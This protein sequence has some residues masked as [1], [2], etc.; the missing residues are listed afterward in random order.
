[1]SSADL[2]AEPAHTR[3]GGAPRPRYRGAF[4]RLFR[5]EIRLIL[6]RRRNI[7]LLVVLAMVPMFIGIAVDISKPRHGD[8][9]QFLGQITG[10]G[11]FLVFT[12]LT[13]SLPFFF[14]LVVG[15]ISGDCIAGEANIGTLRYLLTVPVTRGRLL[16]VKALAVA[17]FSMVAVAVM[18]LVGLATGFLLFG[19]HSVTLLSGD[20][21]SLGSGLLRTLGIAVYVCIALFGLAAIGLFISTLTENAIGAMAATIG[22]AIFSALLDAV[23]QLSAI[24]P[25]LLTDHWLGFGELLR[26]SISYADLLSWT[27]LHV[28]YIVI[29]LSLAWSRIT[30]KDVTS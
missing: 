3:H 13:V 18:T 6:T 17:T 4:L 2:G 8:G 28:A 19:L 30:T 10:N 29:F 5:G 20:T 11:L 12:A 21:V 26:T 25:I 23:P 27:M 16:A 24:H 14:P 9:P 15:V 1:M 22:V 7:A